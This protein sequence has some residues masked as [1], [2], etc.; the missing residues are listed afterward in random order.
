MVGAIQRLIHRDDIPTPSFQAIANHIAPTVSARFLCRRLPRP[1]RYR[2][3]NL[4][5]AIRIFFAVKV[6]RSVMHFTLLRRL[7]GHKLALVAIAISQSCVEL[8]AL[9][10]RLRS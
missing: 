8:A 1:D 5:R 10:R 2:T 9:L 3:F 6:N 4:C 7:C